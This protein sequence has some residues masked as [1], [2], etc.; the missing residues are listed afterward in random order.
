MHSRIGSFDIVST[1]SSFITQ[2]RPSAVRVAWLKSTPP[3]TKVGAVCCFAVFVIAVIREFMEEISDE[4]VDG[5]DIT[6]MRAGKIDDISSND[7][8]DEMSSSSE[9]RDFS[10]GMVLTPE[11]A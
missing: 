2:R 7:K 5:L 9:E 6:S 11:F 4:E 8:E 1:V 10:C 3:G